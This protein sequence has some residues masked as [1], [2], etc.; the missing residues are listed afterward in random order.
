MYLVMGKVNPPIMI[1]VDDRDTAI[2]MVDWLKANYMY[3]TDQW[4]FKPLPGY[5][6][7]QD[8]MQEFMSARERRRQNAY[9]SRAQVES[10][11]AQMAL[12]RSA[13]RQELNRAG[14]MGYKIQAIKRVRN[15][16][17]LGL[18]DAKDMVEDIADDIL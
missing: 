5:D 1:P 13:V 4:G 8:L 11:S 12:I 17:R 2:E 16:A 15:I 6:R 3:D 10:D 9:V 14:F 18:K 7:G